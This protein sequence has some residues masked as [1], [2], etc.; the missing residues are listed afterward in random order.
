[1][2]CSKSR[3]ILFYRWGSL[4]INKFQQSTKL[5][6]KNLFQIWNDFNIE[7]TWKFAD[8]RIVQR[9]GIFFNKLMLLINSF[10]YGIAIALWLRQFSVNDQFMVSS[11]IPNV[12]QSNKYPGSYNYEKIVFSFVFR[13]FSSLSTKGVI[14]DFQKSSVLDAKMSEWRRNRYRKWEDWWER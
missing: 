14:D 10:I 3:S 4:N 6:S 2:C 12:F 9:S 11:C 8:F 13:L 7:K 1:V 5:L